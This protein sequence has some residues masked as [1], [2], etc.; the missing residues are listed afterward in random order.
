MKCRQ[1]IA[2]AI[3][4]QKL[5]DGSQIVYIAISGCRSSSQSPGVSFVALGVV[6]KPTFAVGIVIL[7]IV[8]PDIYVFPVL[9]AKLPLPVDGHCRNDSATLYSGMP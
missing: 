6:E 1:V 7:S 2:T 3:D 8:V 5:H 9:G 4:Y